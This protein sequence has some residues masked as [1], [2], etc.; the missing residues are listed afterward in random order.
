[1]WCGGETEARKGAPSGT[2]DK[3]GV[4]HLGRGIP[5]TGSR[6]EPGYRVGEGPA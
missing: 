2:R 3:G 5:A 6:P 1:M 4:R